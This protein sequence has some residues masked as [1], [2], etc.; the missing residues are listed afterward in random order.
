MAA[1]DK[2]MGMGAS[3]SRQFYRDI[4]EFFKEHSEKQTGVREED[5]N[6]MEVGIATGHTSLYL[7]LMYRHVRLVDNWR[8]HFEGF[9]RKNLDDPRK[10]GVLHR[11]LRWKAK[12]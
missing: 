11:Y 3:L 4:Y 2:C 10:T 1:A 7:A 8:G 6:W 5:L 9:A 12:E